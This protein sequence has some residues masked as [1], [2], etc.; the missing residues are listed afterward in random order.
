[1]SDKELEEIRR[2]KLEELKALMEEKKREE[3]RAAAEVE[4]V[5]I[6][7]QILTP[8]ARSRL[9]NLRLIRPQL[10]AALENYLISLYQMGRITRQITDD[11]LK[12][13]LA[14]LVKKRREYRIKRL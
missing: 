8:E 6:L 14:R 13:M 11:E 5:L 9:A 1:M 12:R 7:R 2:R 10:V 4:K 3:E